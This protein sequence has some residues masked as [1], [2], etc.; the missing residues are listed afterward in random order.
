MN[1]KYEKLTFLVIL[2]VAGNTLAGLVGHWPL[3][4]ASGTIA[5]DVSGNGNNGVFKGDPKWIVG[6]KGGALEFD[7]DDYIDCGNDT[8]LNFNGAISISVWIRPEADETQPIA[9]LCKANA[10]PAGWSWQLRYGWDSPKPYMGFVFNGTGGRVWIYVNQNLILNEWCHIA[11]SYNGNTVKCYLNG[12]ET[13]SA[14]MTGFAAGSSPLLIGQDGWYDGWIGAI[15]DVRIY[16]HGLYEA[17]IRQLYCHGSGTP[18]PAT[19]LKLA[20]EL[21][22]ARSIVEK[23]SP[24]N[25]IVFLEKKIAEYELWK[26]DNTSEDKVRDDF[27]FSEL[28]FLLARA[29]EAADAPKN[30][31]ATAYKQSILQQSFGRHYVPALLWL[32][33]NTSTDVYTDVVKKS[34][35]YSNGARSNL[36]YIAK[37]FES[38]KN[39]AAFKL[40]LDVIFDEA[41]QPVSCAKAIATGLRKNG[42]WTDNFW[43]NAK[44]TPQLTQYVIAT[45]EEHAQEMISQNKFVRAAEIYHEIINQCGSEEDKAAYELKALECIFNNGEY[46]RVSSE[47]RSF[48]K[49]NG[50]TDKA[51]VRRTILLTA[52]AYMHLNE[53]DRAIA[54]FSKL[55]TDHP[56]SEQTQEANFFI[57]YCRMLKGEYEEATKALNGVIRDCPQSS[58]ANKARLCLTRI[59][60]E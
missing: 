51:L 41:S 13:D 10:G 33:K 42:L 17:E 46:R 32:F 6:I 37:D 28:N 3:D 24:Q 11:A 27:L 39:W 29:R 52:H 1:K 48:V 49:N 47:L 60:K 34:M 22:K 35:R 26:E 4:E 16:D 19:L 8:S 59:M 45:Y 55:V 5:H 2:I 36:H 23:Q 25:A 15:D 20:D 44:S 12:K 30:D 53:I 14:D 9:P 38:S 7:G 18:V 54:A 40:F 31:I 57:G 21:H 56:Y 50:F 43:E 58:Y